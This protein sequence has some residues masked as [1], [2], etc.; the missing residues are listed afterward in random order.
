MS[1][2]ATGAAKV[3]SKQQR[4]AISSAKT[5]AKLSVGSQDNLL[6]HEV[7]LTTISAAL[8]LAQLVAV[9]SCECI[10]AWLGCR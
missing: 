4:Q 5:R 9:Y 6:Q 2:L 10:P 3:A 8:F 1:V 7:C